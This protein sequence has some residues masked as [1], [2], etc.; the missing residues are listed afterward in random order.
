MSVGQKRIRKARG[1]V[2]ALVVGAALTFFVV[3]AQAGTLQLDPSFG[4][5]GHVTTDIGSSSNDY[6]TAIQQPSG[7]SGVFYTSG[8]S[9][10]SGSWDFAIERYKDS[11]LHD[12][13]GPG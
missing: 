2:P 9:N 4:S 3:G 5:G 1:W 10:A 13:Y 7:G 8:C 11:G 6:I 12:S